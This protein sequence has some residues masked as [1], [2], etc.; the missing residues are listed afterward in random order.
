MSKGADFKP[1]NESAVNQRGDTAPCESGEHVILGG[2]RAVAGREQ[3]VMGPTVRSARRD[4]AQEIDKS[5]DPA[6]R[7]S[8]YWFKQARL[9]LRLS[10]DDAAQLFRCARNTILNWENRRTPIPDECRIQLLDRLVESGLLTEVNALA[11]E[12]A[13]TLKKTA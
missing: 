5:D 1:E 11:E 3:I 9:K 6:R 12:H 7:R 4:A 8:A 2:P 10:L 13:R